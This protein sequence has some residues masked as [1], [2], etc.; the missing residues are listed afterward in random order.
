[1]GIDQLYFL[2]HLQIFSVFVL[3]VTKL[4]EALALPTQRVQTSPSV[5]GAAHFLLN[6][7]PY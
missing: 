4:I 2:L 6:G 7:L 3:K 1:M 5:L